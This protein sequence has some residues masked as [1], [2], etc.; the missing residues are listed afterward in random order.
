MCS[1]V[2]PVP[3]ANEVEVTVSA[4]LRGILAVA[5]LGWISSLG[6]LAFDLRLWVSCQCGVMRTTTA[7]VMGTK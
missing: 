4:N 7:D 5:A 6:G 2:R 3:M 1:C